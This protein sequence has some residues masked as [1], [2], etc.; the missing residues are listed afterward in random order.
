MHSNVVIGGSLDSCKNCGK[1]F[2]IENLNNG[3]C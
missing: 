2:W 3:F 1:M